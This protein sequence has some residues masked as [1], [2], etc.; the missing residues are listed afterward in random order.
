MIIFI[1]YG[2]MGKNFFFVL[3]KERFNT[4]MNE[5]GFKRPDQLKGILGLRNM[6]MTALPIKEGAVPSRMTINIS[7]SDIYRLW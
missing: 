7:T 1:I 6:S 5:S 4:I 2:M 3:T